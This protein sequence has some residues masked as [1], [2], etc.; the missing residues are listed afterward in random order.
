MLILE[1]FLYVLAA[2]TTPLAVVGVLIMIAAWAAIAATAALGA[3]VAPLA[4]FRWRA[5]AR[6]S[7]T[8]SLV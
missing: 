5:S 1:P 2:M 6:F 3:I 7:E 8:R 4:L